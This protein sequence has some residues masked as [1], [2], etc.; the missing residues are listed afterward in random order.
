MGMEQTNSLLHWNFL[1]ALEDDIATII[2]FIEPTTKNEKTYS[3]ELSRLLLSAA[4]EVDVIAKLLC[5]KYSDNQVKNISQYRE[6]LIKS[7]PRIGE[8]KVHFPRL[9]LVFTPWENWSTDKNPDWW[10]SYNN[11]KHQRN[12]YF[13]Q[14][15]LKNA[16]NAVAGLFILVIFYYRDEAEVGLLLPNPR[17]LRAGEPFVLDSL[18]WS[19]DRAIVYQFVNFFS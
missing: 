2:R 7:I 15:T 6:I 9:G 4:S 13:N 5:K 8:I 16:F 3:L 17:L 12:E 1:L 11:V 18:M 19:E 14:A 10:K